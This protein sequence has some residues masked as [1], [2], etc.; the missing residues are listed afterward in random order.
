MNSQERIAALEGLLDRIK[1][2]AQ[3]PRVQPALAPVVAATPAAAAPAPVAEPELDAIDI[4]IELEPS[5]APAPV[6]AAPVDRFD[7]T[8]DELL[9]APIPLVH[10]VA[11]A[12][13]VKVAE[14]VSLEPPPPPAAEALSSLQ[15]G[16]EGE[17]EEAPIPLVAAA[18]SLPDAPAIS[19]VQPVGHAAESAEE[20]EEDDLLS[21]PPEAIKSEPPPELEQIA[22]V[23]DS[24]LDFDDED[25]RSAEEEEMPASSKRAR[26]DPLEAALSADQVLEHEVPIKTPPPE[27]G[28]QEAAPPAAALEAPRLPELGESLDRVSATLDVGPT[29]EQL[30]D[31]IEL[32]E[33]SQANL[34]LDVRAPV[35]EAQPI[36]EELELSL[37][38]RESVGVFDDSLTPPASAREELKRYEEQAAPSVEAAP[39]GTPEATQVVRRP[40]LAGVG[41]TRFLAAAA[42]FAPKSFVELLDA[43]LRLGSE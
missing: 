5:P 11:A 14:P 42:D 3:R 28:P 4:T 30:G 12:P 23:D 35:V 37:P 2:N 8:V 32:P 38:K 6:A 18:P 39:S 29:P 43:S 34:E 13:A 9:E 15:P 31:T 41:A 17:G 24:E 40:S 16:S 33:P 26:V 22:S 36:S 7:E 25:D 10:A 19:G 20:L 21:V 27:S 1:R